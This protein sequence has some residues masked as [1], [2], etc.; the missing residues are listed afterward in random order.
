MAKLI[1]W[2]PTN[3][4]GW[5]SGLVGS[6]SKMMADAPMEATRTGVKAAGASKADS[7]PV[8][9]TAIPTASDTRSVSRTEGN[10]VSGKQRWSKASILFFPRKSVRFRTKQF[11]HHPG[12]IGV[13]LRKP[14]PPVSMT[15]INNAGLR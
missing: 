2:P 6:A 10:G 12:W 1:I 8:N 5:A 4:Q 11:L 3:G 15:Q 14:E 7:N 9:N 13:N